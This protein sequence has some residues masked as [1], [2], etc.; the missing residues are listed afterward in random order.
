M[1]SGPNWARRYGSRHSRLCARPGCGAAADATL[2][3]QSTRREAWL[4]DLDDEAART[5][6][7]LCARHADTLVLPRGWALHD[8]RGRA[9][10]P[11]PVDPGPAAPEEKVPQPPDELAAVLDAR[12]PLLQR[13]FRSAW[14]GAGDESNDESGVGG[15]GGADAR[16]GDRD[17]QRDRREHE[18][19]GA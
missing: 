11:A 2:R 18:Q 8:D 13:A 3:F 1:T 12:T 9:A 7:D 17:E 6:G 15:G 10:R 5:H 14:P 19:P 4:V 16:G